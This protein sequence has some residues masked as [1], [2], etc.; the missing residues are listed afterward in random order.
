[1]PRTA[2]FARRVAQANEIVSKL[3]AK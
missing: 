1:L 3:P 2:E